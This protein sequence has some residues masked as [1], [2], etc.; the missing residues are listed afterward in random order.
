MIDQYTRLIVPNICWSPLTRPSRRTDD[1]SRMSL[2]DFDFA[3]LLL[4]LG[5]GK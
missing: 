4:D 1:I 3:G 5:I 2:D